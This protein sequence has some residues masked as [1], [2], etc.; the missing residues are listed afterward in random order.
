MTRH[1]LLPRWLGAVL[2]FPSDDLLVCGGCGAVSRD[3]TLL[4]RAM[5]ALFLVP[6]LAI[7]VGGLATAAWLAWQVV[8]DRLFDAGWAL[9]VVG[10]AGLGSIALHR[11]VRVLRRLLSPRRKL[12]MAGWGTGL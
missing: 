3:E 1:D 4:D 10:L 12:P 8:V 2:L 11:T 9:G 5:S 7:S 6:F